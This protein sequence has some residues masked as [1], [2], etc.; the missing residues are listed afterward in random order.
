MKKLGTKLIAG[1][2]FILIMIVVV[3]L[4]SSIASQRSLRDSIGQNSV[5]MANEILVNMN[6]AIYNF[7]DRLE[8]RA[9]DHGT[10]AVVRS[11]N[12][13]FDAMGSVDA[14][15]ERMSAAWRTPAQGEPSAAVRQVVG[16]EES[17]ELRQIYFQHYEEKQGAPGVTHIAIT[18]RFGALVAATGIGSPY[19]YDADALWLSAKEGSS[20]AGSIAQDA[21]SGETVLPLGIP[22]RDPDGAFMGVI[23]ANLQVDSI[24]RNAI[25]TYKKYRT[26]QVKLMTS[27][28]KLIYA[29]KA[30]RF[31]DDISQQEYFENMKGDSGVFVAMEGG[32]ATLFS[33]AREQEYLSFPGMSWILLV[34]HD[35]SEVL[36]PSFAL[37]NN[38]IIASAILIV[39]G[40]LLAFLLARSITKPVA[41]LQKAAAE[42]AKG[43]LEH[44][45]KVRSRDELGMLARSF[46]EMREALQHIA[47]MAERTASGDLTG[48]FT[49]RSESDSLGSA[50]RVMVENL[51][52]QIA[53]IQEGA[54]VVASAASEISTSTSQFV[55]NASETSVAVSQT[56]TTI[57]EVKQTAHLSHE[58]AKQ[59]AERARRAEEVAQAGLESVR[60]TAEVIGGIREQMNAIGESITRLNE[61]NAAIGEVT[62]TVSDLA[63]QSNLLSVNAAIE[64]AKAG[65][66]GK[67]FGVVA[68]AIRE[69]AEQSKRATAQVRK[70]L[71]DTQKA[72]AAAVLAT[73][74][75]SKAVERGMKQA[76][77]AKQSIEA[78]SE[79]VEEAVQAAAQIAASSQQQ[80]VGMDQVATAMES[81]KVASEQSV[82]GTKQ[83]EAGAQNLQG[84]GQKMKQLVLF[85]KV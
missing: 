61:Q 82:A 8:V 18:N 19:R 14:Y 42:I 68:Q 85:Y 71:A 27:E 78:L 56:T 10:Q 1:F 6:M 48:S 66:Q 74:Q 33:F 3:G 62:S 37:R 72:T 30:Y 54:T 31:L 7:I 25:I 21:A 52:R 38:I 59:T 44:E 46:G 50:L 65:E 13:E 26:T 67:G 29:T 17:E 20:V 35:V 60:G 53:E 28:G 75:G 41:L 81:I 12:R 15:M 43:N 57:E 34:G 2:G 64:A 11:S 40:V 58:K 47:A 51:Q 4:Y 32:R 69:L 16:S 22:I 79:T 73:E 39:L 24:I 49:P 76:E 70:I 63:D 55:V 80:L 45:I 36:A 23:L 9:M 5:F 83:L 84:V 77:E